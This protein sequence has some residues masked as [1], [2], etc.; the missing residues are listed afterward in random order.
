MGGFG[1]LFLLLTKHH[2]QNSQKLWLLIEYPHLKKGFV[3]SLSP[4]MILYCR[5]GQHAALPGFVQ[6]LR[7]YQKSH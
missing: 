5:G 2:V 6:L 3:V 1:I 4:L 7:N